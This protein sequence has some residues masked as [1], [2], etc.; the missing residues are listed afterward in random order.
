MVTLTLLPSYLLYRQVG[1]LA[2]ELLI[3][4]YPGVTERPTMLICGSLAYSRYKL[5]TV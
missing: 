5:S 4:K 3:F 1:Q 2:L